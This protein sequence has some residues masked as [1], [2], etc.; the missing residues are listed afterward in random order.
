[1]LGGQ[2]TYTLPKDQTKVRLPVTTNNV[3]YEAGLWGDG[4]SVVI[5]KKQTNEIVF[6]YKTGGI[7]SE[8]E[9]SYL[10]CGNDNDGHYL[11][12]DGRVTVACKIRIVTTGKCNK[13]EAKTS[14]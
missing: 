10:I 13:R 14:L 11:R 3:T 7:G 4:Y 8:S 9:Q 2:V 12:S 1:M 5:S 6:V